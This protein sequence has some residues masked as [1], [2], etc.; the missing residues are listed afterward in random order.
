MNW[1]RSISRWFDCTDTPHSVI[2]LDR[3]STSHAMWRAAMWSNLMS[4]APVS[5]TA[6]LSL[7]VPSLRLLVLLVIAVF[8]PKFRISMRHLWRGI[9]RV[10]R[11]YYCTWCKT[12][13][14]LI[15]FAKNL[16]CIGPDLNPDLRG[17]IH[18]LL[19]ALT[20][21][22]AGNM[23]YSRAYLLSIIYFLLVRDDL[24]IGC[25]NAYSD[26]LCQ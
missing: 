13:S 12:I 11:K 22:L 20:A 7:K 3:T 6:L 16:I 25:T 14:T 18:S 9:G 1:I 8:N 10:A 15:F 17:N 5:D 24:L 23:L 21:Y 4:S 19:Y 2:T 26:M